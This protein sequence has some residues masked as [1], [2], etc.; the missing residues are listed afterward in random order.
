[1]ISC[2]QPEPYGAVKDSDRQEE[3]ERVEE[4]E[5]ER[6][7][8]EKRNNADERIRRTIQNINVPSEFNSLFIGYDMPLKNESMNDTIGNIYVVDRSSNACEVGINAYKMIINSL[9]DF[10]GKGEVVR[11]DYS[12]LT[13]ARSAKEFDNLSQWPIGINPSKLPNYS[14]L[15]RIRSRCEEIADILNGN[16]RDFLERAKLDQ[17][18]YRIVNGVYVHIDGKQIRK[19]LEDELKSKKCLDEKVKKEVQR[20]QRKEEKELEEEQERIYRMNNPTYSYDE[21]HAKILDGSLSIDVIHKYMYG[22]YP[23]YVQLVMSP[24]SYQYKIYYFTI[25]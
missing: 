7:I 1:M 12:L 10:I 4:A 8:K 20:A 24:K 2:Q 22:K 23:I 16:H 15:Y 3:R 6:I 13:R 19:E 11:G 25:I 21:M 14:D 5:Q 18:E 17:G 9:N